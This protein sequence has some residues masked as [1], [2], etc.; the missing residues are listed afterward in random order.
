MPSASDRIATTVTLGVAQRADGE[1]KILHTASG[2]GA[3]ILDRLHDAAVVGLA[4]PLPATG[5]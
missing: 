4:S 1:A 3:G 2:D 5:C